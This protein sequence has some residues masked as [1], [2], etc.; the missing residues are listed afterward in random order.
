MKIKYITGDLFKTEHKYIV[1]G[2]NAQGK[3]GK[4]VAK[5]MRELFPKAYDE[6]YNLWLRNKSLVPGTINI[7]D[8]GSK[9]IIN[10]ITQKYYAGFYGDPVRYVSYDAV[11]DC[12][13]AINETIPGEY[14]AMP[15]I[16]AQLG[17]GNWE[18]I[19][20]IIEEE[21]TDVYPVVYVQ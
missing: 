16:G 13:K 9:T 20:K 21:L 14:L 15:R 1:H 5:T 18:I 17:G 10:A 4:G 19:R 2:C 7:V 3:M 11:A 6:Y 12:M 8:C